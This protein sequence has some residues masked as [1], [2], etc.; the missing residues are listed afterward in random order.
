VAR[1]FDGETIELT[2]V[3]PDGAMACDTSIATPEAR[4]GLGEALRAELVPP[5]RSLPD[6]VEVRF[7]PEGWDA[8]QRYVELESQCC[9]FL[10]LRAERTHDHVV[11][12]VTGRPDAKPW[13]DQ[14]FA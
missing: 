1:A 9:S 13:I 3:N 10:T 2:A 12:T 4:D 6:G 8:V 11:L 5:V 14:I 7:R